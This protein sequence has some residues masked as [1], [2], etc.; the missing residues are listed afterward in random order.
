MYTTIAR[1]KFVDSNMPDIVGEY[2]S[3]ELA[4]KRAGDLLSCYAGVKALVITWRDNSKS[5]YSASGA[6]LFTIPSM[7][8]VK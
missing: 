4:A 5:V 2:T 6:H 8:V 1:L 7:E 3:D